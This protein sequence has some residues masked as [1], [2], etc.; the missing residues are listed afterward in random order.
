MCSCV[1]VEKQEGITQPPSG[2]K[3]NLKQG[4]KSAETETLFIIKLSIEGKGA[5]MHRTRHPNTQRK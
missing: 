3:R 5:A 4:R 1:C 2:L